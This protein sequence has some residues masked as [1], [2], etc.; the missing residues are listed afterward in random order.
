MGAVCV[1]NTNTCDGRYQQPMN[2]S[3]LPSVP[4]DSTGSVWFSVATIN[5]IFQFLADRLVASTPAAFCSINPHVEWV[6]NR[7]RR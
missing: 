6:E 2:T 3:E 1:A 4:V 7:L 5:R